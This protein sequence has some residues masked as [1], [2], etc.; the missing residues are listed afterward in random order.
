MS[1]LPIN[2]WTKF[3]SMCGSI[4]VLLNLCATG[5]ASA[6]NF[7]ERS[8]VARIINWPDATARSELHHE[9]LPFINTLT[10]AYIYR[11][12]NG[13]PVLALRLDWVADDEVI[14]RGQRVPASEVGGEIFIAA[15]DLRGDVMVDGRRVGGLILEVDSMRLNPV[16]DY[17]DVELPDLTWD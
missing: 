4:L 11:I 5:S 3:W 7:D 10:I 9:I 16:P 6:Q 2:A 1:T 14:F 13:S 17:V 12:E 8:G 15:L